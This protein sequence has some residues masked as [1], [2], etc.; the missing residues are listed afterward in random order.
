MS[1]RIFLDTNILLYANIDDGSEK[2]YKCHKL[3]TT[4]LVGSEIVVS[5]QVLNEYYVNVQKKNIP[6]SVIQSTIS[7]FINDFE[8]TPLTKE[9]IPETFDI[10]NRYHFSYWDSNIISAALHGN[11]D[12]LYTEDLQDG[13]IISNRLKIINPIL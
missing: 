5:T 10:L 13:Q 1:N 2:H 8:V 6:F 7:Q 3:L 11:C 4:T 12:I 9:P